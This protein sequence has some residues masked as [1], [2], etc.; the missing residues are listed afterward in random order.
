MKLF[1]FQINL[2]AIS[3][4]PAFSWKCIFKKQDDHRHFLS[5]L[6]PSSGAGWHSMIVTNLLGA[7]WRAKHEKK[8]L[9]TKKILFNSPFKLRLEAGGYMH[10]KLQWWN[11]CWKEIYVAIYNVYKDYL[12]ISLVSSNHACCKRCMRTSNIISIYY[13]WLFFLS[14]SILVFRKYKI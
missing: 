12:I 8:K 6:A 4:F 9:T 10:E 3:L 13:N 2:L 14:N 11:A 7:R 5:S 1:P